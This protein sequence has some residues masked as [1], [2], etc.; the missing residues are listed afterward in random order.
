MY[1][2]IILLKYKYF[3]CYLPNADKTEFD[4]ALKIAVFSRSFNTCG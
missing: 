1:W 3:S 2:R 4:A